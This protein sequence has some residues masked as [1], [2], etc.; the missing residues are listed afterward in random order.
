MPEAGLRRI[1]TRALLDQLS[2]GD[3]DEV[4]ALDALLDGL[5]RRAFGV[6]LFL[7]IP[8]AFFPGV[9]AVIGAPVVILVGM[10]LLLRRQHAWLPRFLDG[11]GP[12]RSLFARFEARFSRWLHRLERLVKPRWPAMIDHPLA[13]MFTGLLLVLLGILLALPIPFTN[14][15]FAVLLLLIALALLERDGALLLFG[16]LAGSAAVAVLGVASGELATWAARSIDH[17]F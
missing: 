9:A 5:G 11:R 13:S 15:A 10:Q 6:L 1:G 8:P 17:L 7:A 16:W 2:E 14:V 12:Q 4:L 3:P